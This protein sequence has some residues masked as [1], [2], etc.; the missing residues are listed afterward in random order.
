MAGMV[1]TIRA[2]GSLCGAVVVSRLMTLRG[3][4]H[5][6]MLLDQVGDSQSALPWYD[7]KSD[8]P[9]RWPAGR[10]PGNG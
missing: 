9:G 10:R 8:W 7:F 5:R 1:N 3:D 4:F 6:E 2:I